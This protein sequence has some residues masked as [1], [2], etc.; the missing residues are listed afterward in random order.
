MEQ[1]HIVQFNLLSTLHRLEERRARRYTYQD[2]ASVAGLNRQNIRHL[3]KS[4]PRRIDMDTLAALLDFFAAEG[5]PVT[6]D[7]L[8]TVTEQPPT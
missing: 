5:M 4:P 7:Q 2:I 8:F 1:K 6:I 3:L